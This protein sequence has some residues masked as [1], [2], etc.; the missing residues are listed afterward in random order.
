M[1]WVNVCNGFRAVSAWGIWAAQLVEHPTLSFSSG[2]DFRVIRWSPMSSPPYSQTWLCAQ[3]GVCIQ[4]LSELKG[5]LCD[6]APWFS[7]R[8]SLSSMWLALVS[9]LQTQQ[10]LWWSS[11]P[12][13][14]LKAGRDPCLSSKTMRSREILFYY[15][16]STHAFGR[17]YRPTHTGEGN[18]LYSVCWLK[19]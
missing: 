5:P 18:L 17:L 14:S 9:C 1:R 16:D 3:W 6:S 4:P 2:H 11:S 12:L 13:L 15:S 19:C 7:P 10:S 8:A